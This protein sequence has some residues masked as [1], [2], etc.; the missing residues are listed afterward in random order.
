[1]FC[2]SLAIGDKKSGPFVPTGDLMAGTFN[3]FFKLMCT[4]G[5]HK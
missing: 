1:M 3:K 4:K 5:F 2:V